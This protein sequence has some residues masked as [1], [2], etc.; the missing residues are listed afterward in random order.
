VQKV[1]KAI[2]FCKNLLLLLFN[3]WSDGHRR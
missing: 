1:V 2:C 3:A